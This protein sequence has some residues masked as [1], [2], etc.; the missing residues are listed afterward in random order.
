MGKW[1][2]HREAMKISRGVYCLRHLVEYVSK[3]CHLL[4][5]NHRFKTS[6]LLEHVIPS[7]T[8]RIIHDS[9]VTG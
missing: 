7:S 5:L 9:Y 6:N 8:E 3:N 1:C 2:P 4:T